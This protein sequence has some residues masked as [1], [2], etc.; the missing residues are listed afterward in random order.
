MSKCTLCP[1]KCGAD[2][3]S[4]RGFC[5]AG[6]GLR[7]ARAALHEWEEPP[8]TGDSGSGAVFF[9]GCALRC[10]FCQN[11]EISH[12]CV[13]KTVSPERLYDIFFEL[14][15]A[16]AANINLVTADH[17]LPQ[18]A[19]VAKRARADGLG[20]PFVLNTSSYLSAKQLEIASEFT[21]VYLADL[22]YT[23]PEL[24]MKYS[25]APD[26]PKVARDAI[27]AMYGQTGD[28]VVEGGLIKRGVIVRVLVLPGSII[29][30]KASVRYLYK[31]Y[32]DGV[33][34]SVMGQYV[35][36]GGPVHRE[37]QK[38]LSPASYRSVTRYARSL[39]VTRGFI[40]EEGADDAAYIP[41]FDLRGV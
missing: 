9:S 5:G 40:Q 4:E 13:G 3:E 25:I 10:E 37:L 7:I 32:G 15:N 2:R 24:A 19:P 16:G 31:R 39:G 27:D 22:K 8:L 26:Y 30:A 38:K 14:K 36:V 34:I 23:S 20:I 12:G 18:V 33:F 28:P 11:A 6:S 1:R 41:E 21:D 17:Y 29:D 35:P